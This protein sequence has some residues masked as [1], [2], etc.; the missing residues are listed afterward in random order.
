M[1]HKFDLMCG[2]EALSKVSTLKVASVACRNLGKFKTI[3][4]HGISGEF[5]RQVRDQRSE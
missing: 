5:F 1:Y 2:R 4:G 3:G